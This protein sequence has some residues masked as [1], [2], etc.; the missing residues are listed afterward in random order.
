MIIWVTSESLG[1]TSNVIE[2]VSGA[3]IG[4]FASALKE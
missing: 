3:M 2:R 4:Y 1:A